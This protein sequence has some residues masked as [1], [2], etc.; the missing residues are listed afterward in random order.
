MKKKVEMSKI[1]KCVVILAFEASNLY[2]NL[3]KYDY[4][5]RLNEI[6][7]FCKKF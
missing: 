5:V 2:Y 3:H 1:I 4:Y 7:V 6:I